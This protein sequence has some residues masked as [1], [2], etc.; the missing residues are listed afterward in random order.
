[1]KL[2][3][4]TF[5]SNTHMPETLTI[6][7]VRNEPLRMGLIGYFLSTLVIEFELLTFDL[8]AHFTHLCHIYTEFEAS[9]RYQTS[10]NKTNI[11][12][13]N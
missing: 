9:N 12:L 11:K 3:V 8:K 2:Y 6:G 5:D 13:M 10:K 7:A 4:S 1:M